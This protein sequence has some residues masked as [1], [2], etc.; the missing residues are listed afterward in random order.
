MISLV[1]VG[2]ERT[3]SKSWVEVCLSGRHSGAW[4]ALNNTGCMKNLRLII[5]P[6]LH[7]PLANVEKIDKALIGLEDIAEIVQTRVECSPHHTYEFVQSARFP[8][9]QMTINSDFGC[10]IQAISKQLISETSEQGP[11]F[12]LLWDGHNELALQKASKLLGSNRDLVCLNAKQTFF[13]DTI[14]GQSPAPDPIAD[15][16]KSVPLLDLGNMLISDVLLERFTNLESE[17]ANDRFAALTFAKIAESRIFTQ[18]SHGTLTARKRLLAMAMVLEYYFKSNSDAHTNLVNYAISPHGVREMFRGR[19]EK[20]ASPKLVN[21]Y[22]GVISSQLSKAHLSKSMVGN[23]SISTNL[24][25]SLMEGNL[26]WSLKLV[27]RILENQRNFLKPRRDD[28]SGTKNELTQQMEIE[29]KSEGVRSGVVSTLF[30]RF[31]SESFNETKNKATHALR[32]NFPGGSLKPVLDFTFSSQG[33]FGQHVDGWSFVMQRFLETSG[34]DPNGVGFDSFLE[35][36]YV[37]GLGNGVSRRLKPWIGV[38]HRPFNIPHFYDQK[39]KLHFFQTVEFIMD[40]NNLRGLIT[41]GSEHGKQLRELLGIPVETVLHPTNLDVE[42]W[43]LSCLSRSSPPKL[44]QIGSW[45]RNMHSIFRM[46]ECSLP[47][48][49]LGGSR[50]ELLSSPRFLAEARNQNDGALFATEIY[51]QVEFLPRLSNNEYNDLLRECVVF[52]DL[53]DAT[54]NNAVLECIAR[55]TPLLVN[56]IPATVEYLGSQ[57]PLFYDDLAEAGEKASDASLLLAAHEY[58][59]ERAQLPELSVANFAD[60]I[61]ATLERFNLS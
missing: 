51:E 21:L 61:H 53:Y 10:L 31:S 28:F 1:A 17:V 27:N 44:V 12:N 7:D 56:R 43:D 2:K 14:D 29:E 18:I 33:G 58:L 57:Y 24:V 5:L 38:S 30:R 37:W 59:V 46:P 49:I 25:V 60:N 20:S 42:K 3:V 22:A 55:H 40:S 32:T 54:A 36:T 15:V 35:K 48:A 13:L 52:L 9:H 8:H 39:S 4:K 45:L 41:V 16:P 19:G 6:V 34:H 47:R 11:F 26:N 23:C 50:E